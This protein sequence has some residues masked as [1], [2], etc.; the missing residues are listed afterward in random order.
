LFN[1]FNQTEANELVFSLKIFKFRNQSMSKLKL[2]ITSNFITEQKLN[3]DFKI[4]I[5][6][7]MFVK[8][9]HAIA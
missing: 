2:V 1:F 8:C 5:L 7:V 4:Q 6:G 9:N 3:S